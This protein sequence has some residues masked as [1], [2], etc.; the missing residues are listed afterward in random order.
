M[1]STY[2]WNW[3]RCENWALKVDAWVAQTQSTA[4]RKL[5]L[6]SPQLEL[7]GHC[8]KGV[9]MFIC[10]AHSLTHTLTHRVDEA[11]AAP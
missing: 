10:H 8:C 1:Q 2:N 3:G 6:L 9:F 4:V 5:T 7:M 11:Y